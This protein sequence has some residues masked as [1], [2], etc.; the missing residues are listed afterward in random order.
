MGKKYLTIK[1]W[2]EEYNGSAIYS[3]VDDDGKRYIGQAKTLQTRLN[4]HR[5]QLNHAYEDN[6]AIVPEG[7]KLIKAVRDGKTFKVQVLK[8]LKWNEATINNL[9]YWE[10]Y[11][12][13]MYGGV[14]NTYNTAPIPSPVWNCEPN[15]EITLVIE[16]DKDIIEA[17]DQVDN[18][19]GYIK[20][21]IRKD[22]KP[23]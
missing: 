3:L 12:L 13:K 18:K 11:Y 23:E 14:N 2:D 20:D 6:E 17:L 21:L 16:T 5:Q 19:Q 4:T 15:N 8:K 22:I 7:E 10:N 9:R 1:K